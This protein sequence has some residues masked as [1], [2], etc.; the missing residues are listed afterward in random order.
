MK[1][2]FL[3]LLIL[4]IS[5]SGVQAS[6]LGDIKLTQNDSVLIVEEGSDALFSW[7]ATKPLVP[8]SLTKL[9][10][11]HLAIEK[12]GLDHRFITD[13]LVDGETL[14]VKGYGDPFL[15]S[16][17]IEK[18]VLVLRKRLSI[19]GISAIKRLSIDNSH[20][21]ITSVP[22]RSNSADPYNAPL[23]AVSANFNTVKLSKK[24]GQIASAEPQT[25][26]TNVARKMAYTMTKSIERVNLLNA[27]NAQLNFA[28]LLLIKLDWLDVDITIGQPLSG[29]AK[30]LYRHENSHTLEDVLRG[31]LEFSNNFMANQ[32]F[33]KLPET[34]NS[35]HVSFESARDYSTAALSDA[36]GWKDHSIDE[37]SGL[38]RK[39]RLSAKQ[40]DELLLALQ[41]NKSLLKKIKTKSKS[42]IVYAKTGTLKG[43]RSYAGYIELP[44]KSSTEATA[45]RYRFVF[46][47]NRAVAYRYRDQA[48]EQLL[49]YLESL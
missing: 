22:G 29:K 49:R 28:E 39:N 48:L 19:N 6:V 17:E 47:F 30:L 20:F 12:W 16:E 36:F 23:S 15:V 7:Q 21:D 46:N 18:L 33:L 2:S 45:R 25:P 34:E 4:C 37:G 40:I 44:P 11:A 42:A 31:T 10:M 43:V 8:A 1:T 5:A 9:A 27:D 41:A 14:W 32:V 35:S 13:F 24:N 38:S 26:L 3:Y